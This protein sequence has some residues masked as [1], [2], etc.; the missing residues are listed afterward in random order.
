ML[1]FDGSDYHMNIKHKSGVRA[2]IVYFTH[3]GRCSSVTDDNSMMLRN[4]GFNYPSEEKI[5]E[6]RSQKEED[7]KL[8]QLKDGKREA[9][10]ALIKDQDKPVVYANPL[11]AHSADSIQK[12]TMED[13]AYLTHVSG[14]LLNTET[15]ALNLDDD[16]GWGNAS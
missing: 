15:R 10:K 12:G 2:S 8:R 3:N 9:M 11:Q 4:Y 1:V 7:N 16:W 14:C 13:E 5:N 6:M